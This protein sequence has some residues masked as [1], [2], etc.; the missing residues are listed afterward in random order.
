MQWLYAR[1]PQGMLRFDE[2]TGAIGEFRA[3]AGYANGNTV[4]RRGRLLSCEH[5]HRRVT[6]T[7]H[8]GTITA[9]TDRY[10]GKRLN[11]PNDLVEH[12]DGAIWFTDPSY[13]IDSDYEGHKAASEIG[14]CP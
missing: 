1:S 11:S 7:E 2:L 5:G 12:S 3:P 8:D 10:D 14:A 4:D 9:L 13:G 6:R